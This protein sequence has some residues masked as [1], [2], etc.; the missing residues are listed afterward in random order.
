MRKAER[1]TLAVAL[2]LLLGGCAVVKVPV[3]VG[4]TAVG[5]AILVTTRDAHHLP[6][7]TPAGVRH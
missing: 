3:K 1:A 5:T 2:L 6:G 4:G 7:G